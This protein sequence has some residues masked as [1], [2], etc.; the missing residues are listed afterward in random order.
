VNVI[1]DFFKRLILHSVKLTGRAF[2]SP[3]ESAYAFTFMAI[4]KRELSYTGAAQKRA[5]VRTAQ[6]YRSV[7]A[8]VEITSKTSCSKS[9]EVCCIL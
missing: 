1:C 6:S 5:I 3:I 8:R 9:N 7:W 2:R 4:H